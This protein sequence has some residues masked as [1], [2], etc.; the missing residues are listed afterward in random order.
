MTAP[1][2]CG[3]HVI[4]Q[5]SFSSVEMADK[6]S[7]KFGV[8]NIFWTGS[9]LIIQSYSPCGDN[10]TRIGVLRWALPH[11]SSF[12]LIISLNKLTCMNMA[13]QRVKLNDKL[14]YQTVSITYYTVVTP[15]L[16]MQHTNHNIKIK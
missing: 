16:S 2:T 7:M 10:S 14:D 4:F 15:T 12:I 9:C 11:I 8:D 1:Y 13:K 3:V 5:Q 6:I